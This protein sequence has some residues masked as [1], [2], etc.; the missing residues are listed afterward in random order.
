MEKLSTQTVRPSPLIEA[1]RARPILDSINWN[2]ST[3]FTVGRSGMSLFDCRK[4]HWYP[5]TFIPEIPYTLIEVLSKPGD[6]VYDPFSGIGTTIFQALLLGRKPYATELGK[7][8]VDFMLSMWELFNPRTD[9]STVLT[10]FDK[11]KATYDPSK[12]YSKALRKTLIKVESLRPW[13]AEGT[14]NQLMYLTLSE[15]RCRRPGTRAA[16]RV[17]LSATFKAACA[18][19]R[20][21]G[22]I[23]DNVLPKPKQKGKEKNALEQFGRKLN[24]LIKELSEIRT[25]LPSTTEK[26]LSTTNVSSRI[27]KVD[28]RQDS[29]VPDSSVDLIVTSPP[30]PNMTDYALSQRLSYYWLG[31]DPSDDL[32]FEIGARRKRNLST[33]I[34]KYRDSMKDVMKV[35]SSKLKI[36]GYACFVMPGFEG[37]KQ[38]NTERKQVVQEC[39]AFLPANG[40]VLEQELHRILPTLR[41]HHNQ[42]WTTLE[43]E[44]IHIY[45]KV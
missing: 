14:F 36:G 9:I 30:Y 39:L 44:Y 5:A 26:F 21:W 22:C 40:L 27:T 2:F 20:G 33:A 7:V 38:N 17:V 11:I 41:R 43:R 45:R 13:Y 12:D 8:S 42:K 16:M 10:D 34:Q 4:H 25:A 24:I 23:A 29:S 6:V 19:D 3:P 28:A 32:A 31:G 37:D 15:T 18:Q 35:L 1:N